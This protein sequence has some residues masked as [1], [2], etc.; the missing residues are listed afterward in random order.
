VVAEFDDAR[1]RLAM[2]SFLAACDALEGNAEVGEVG[3]GDG[4]R[5]FIERADAKTLSEMVL[6]QQLQR[7]GWT[8][9][10]QVAPA[11]SD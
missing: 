3:D 9:P 4:S 1:I 2:R 11:D 10:R 8:A 5:E 6:R 7:L